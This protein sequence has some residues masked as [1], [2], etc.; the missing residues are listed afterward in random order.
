[1]IKTAFGNINYFNFQQKKILIMRWLWCS[2][3][4]TKPTHFVWFLF[5]DPMTQTNRATRAA[6]RRLF[7][8][9]YKRGLRAAS[10]PLYKHVTHYSQRSDFPIITWHSYVD[11]PPIRHPGM[12]RVALL[13][14][15]MGSQ[16]KN[17]TKCV[18]PGFP[19]L[20]SFLYSFYIWNLF[21][22]SIQ[23]QSRLL[24]GR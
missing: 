16:N 10:I 2:L 9:V 8:E 5:W 11:V 21:S 22:C 19:S 1:M 14:W 6:M 3:L 15:V 12:L 13:V 20:P 24:A 17:P 23:L 7:C 4:L 18:G